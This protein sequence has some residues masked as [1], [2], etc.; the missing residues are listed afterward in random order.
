MSRHKLSSWGVQKAFTVIQWYTSSHESHLQSEAEFQRSDLL[1]AQYKE[2]GNATFFN[3]LGRVLQEHIQWAVRL[4]P[5][6]RGNPFEP[7]NIPEPRSLEMKVTKAVKSS[8]GLQKQHIWPCDAPWNHC[9]SGHWRFCWWSSS[10]N[11][12]FFPWSAG[13]HWTLG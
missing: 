11:V 2:I 10:R 9:S 8:H 4:A 12:K 3:I 1:Q 5:V 13:W 6:P 7:W